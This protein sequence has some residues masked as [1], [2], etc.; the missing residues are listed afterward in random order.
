[1]GLREY[2]K[3]RDFSR[4]PEPV[5]GSKTHGGALRF[6]VQRHKAR[7]LHYDLRLEMEGVLKSWAVPK[8]PSMNP[9][10][11]RLAI[12]TEDHPLEYLDFEGTIPKGNYGAGTMT[13]WDRGIYHPVEGNERELIREW[14]QGSMK[15]TFS[16]SKLRGTFSLIRT[17]KGE[18]EN[19][20]L[21]IKKK[22][23]LASD[24]DYDAEN[25]S[26]DGNQR[27]GKNIDLHKL[28]KPMLATK[29]SSIF[30]KPGWI[31]EIKWDG[32][33]VL[34]NIQEGNVHLY[35]RN[36]ITF[37]QKF[38]SL[39]KHL[40]AVAHDVLL[41]GEVVVVNENGVPDFHQLQNYAEDTEGE[42][43]YYVFDVLFLNGHNTISLP[44]LDRKS[45]IP[46]IIED[47]PH[48][49]YCDH[50]EDV[51]NAFYE[52]VIR[53]GLEGV[54][55]KK[56]D[57]VYLPGTRTENWLKVKSKESQEAIICGYT[58]SKG[59]LFGSLILGVYE[60]GGLVYIGNC[61]SGFNNETQKELLALFKPLKRKNSPFGKKINLKGRQAIWLKPELICEV[62]F[63]QWTKKGLLRHPVFKG[64]REDKM[65]PEI[66]KETETAPSAMKKK[67][68]PKTETLE[69][70]GFDVP[71]SN[72]DKIYWPEE[73]INKFQLISYYIEIA[74]YILP[75]LKD[76]PQNLH[77][78]PEGIDKESFY[79]KDMAATIPDWVESV[80]VYSESTEKDIEYMLCQNE[81]TLVYMANL[82]CIEINPWNSR[83][84]SLEQPDY[85][86]I[87]L[88]PSEKNTF[89]QVIEVAQLAHQI[90]EDAKI[91]H[92]CKTSGSS[93]LH[94]YIPLGAQY[95]YSE[96]RDFVKII[97]H[98]I[99][100]DMPKLTSMERA[101]SSRKDK[102]YLDYLQN[103]K[104]Q[105]LAAPYCVRPKPGAT[106]SAPLEWKEVKKGL[107]IQDFNIFNMPQRIEKKPKLFL[108]ILGKGIDM[109]KALD[110]LGHK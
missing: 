38:P 42:L 110:K 26:D 49:Y 12:Q 68:V 75:F 2:E 14:D 7:R 80:S 45:L 58:T 105:T 32:Y 35:S 104:G 37:N 23:E 54:I 24:L 60:D 101:K 70:N 82:G 43:R 9:K 29:T 66:H 17:G 71:V 92:Y 10:D 74:D 100:D 78:H 64:L 41:D 22:D 102:I 28:V 73:K 18:K 95:S 47:I 56:S 46:E 86:I 27:K 52:K 84:D 30:S 33:R 11:K 62:Q 107:T 3:K 51:G 19:Q 85:A 87:D 31:Y 93:G 6:V 83:A 96:A 16:G 50:V 40:E 106:V 90:L 94:I 59:S 89:D 36:G 44:L 39:T 5:G 53:L 72:L 55:A 20:W 91:K 4:T 61:G 1:M 34:A 57:S 99:H 48:V 108:E 88:D 77:R 65:P 79:Q 109:E 103:R 25:L 13:I 8:G 97:C 63:S 81:A 15:I 21:L 76:R 67:K 69:I 98:L